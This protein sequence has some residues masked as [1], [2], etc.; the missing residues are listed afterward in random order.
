MP[1][2][3][4]SE[5]IQAGESASGPNSAYSCVEKGKGGKGGGNA[6]TNGGKSKGGKKGGKG[7]YLY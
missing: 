4:P 7:G 6:V 5:H 1:G 2:P 3:A